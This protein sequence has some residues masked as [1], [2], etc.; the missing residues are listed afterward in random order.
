MCGCLPGTWPATQA[1]V[2]TGNQTGNP[3]VHR[4]VLNPLSYT[5]QV[6]KNILEEIIYYNRNP[7]NIS[8]A[9]IMFFSS[10]IENS[11][12]RNLSEEKILDLHIQL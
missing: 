1:C 6:L 2:P 3:L 7:L 5:S 4:P 9:L 12:P 8:K 10:D 11:T